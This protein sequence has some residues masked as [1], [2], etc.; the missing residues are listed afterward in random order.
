MSFQAL[1]GTSDLLASDVATWSAVER[2]LRRLAAVYGYREIRTPIIEDAALFLRSVGETSDIVQKEMF[3]F[4]DRGGHQ[5]VLRPEGTAA[6]VRAYLEHSLHKT[7][8]FTKLFYLGPMFRAERPQAG[9]FRQFHQYGVEALGSASPWVDVEVITLAYELAKA[10]GVAATA[11][12]ASMGCRADQERSAEALRKTLAPHHTK[13]CTDCQARF[14]KNIFR[15]LDCKKPEDQKIIASVQTGSPFLLCDDCAKHFDQVREGLRQAGV[16]FTDTAAFA[17]G[18]D[19]YTRTVFE[20]RAPGLGAQDALAAGGRYDH[21]IEDFGGPPMGAA[22]FAGGLERLLIAALHA[23]TPPA[24]P[25]TGHAGG[26]APVRRGVYLATAK[27][28]LLPKAF[29]MV[30]ALRRQGVEATLDYDAGS[31][32]AQMR[33]A[34][35]LGCR[36]VAILGDQ[37]LAKGE[38]TVKDLAQGGAQESIALDRVTEEFANRLK[39]KHACR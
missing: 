8:G 3:R 33:E 19:Y 36:Y 30:A 1:R 39:P 35:K 38:L 34:D 25:T 21:L 5:I 31:L 37:E 2:A 22:G 7:Q 17:R 15:V 23:A 16:P 4:E 6:I 20:L 28:D 12:I 24:P 27:P 29:Q 9:R 11:W 13:L 14:E 10:N 18:L 26:V 32:R